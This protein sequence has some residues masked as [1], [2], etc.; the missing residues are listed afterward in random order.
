M[1]NDYNRTRM[2]NRSRADSRGYTDNRSRMDQRGSCPLCEQ[3]RCAARRY[4]DTRSTRSDLPNN[5]TDC[6]CQNG[7]E[8]LRY[9]LQKLDFSIYE[10]VLYLDAYPHCEEA[11]SMYNHLVAQRKELADEYERQCG[12]IGILGNKSTTSWDWVK[13]TLPWEYGAN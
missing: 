4:S 6:G 11:L 10:L 9:N 3:N 5:S 7:C 13:G 12:P 2:D 1:M 8:Q